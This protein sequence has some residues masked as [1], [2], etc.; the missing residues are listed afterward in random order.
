MIGESHPP[1]AWNRRKAGA[2]DRPDAARDRACSL[3]ANAAERRAMA[4]RALALAYRPPTAG[5]LA[6]LESGAACQDMAGAVEWTPGGA[7]RLA[8]PIERV[9]QAAAQLSTSPSGGLDE[10]SA[11]YARLYGADHGLV[12][13]VES[14][15]FDGE[16]QVEVERVYATHGLHTVA[17]DS[18]AVD[19]VATQLEFVYV[20]C[21]REESAW[22]SADVDAA[23]RLRRTEREFLRRHLATW[24]VA[25]LRATERE[26]T[27]PLYPALAGI[28]RETLAIET[29]ASALR[30]RAGAGS[31]ARPVDRG[32]RPGNANG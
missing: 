32:R 20:L 30:G 4:W 23:K 18:V 27:L 21:R 8:R 26:A 13:S 15:Y 11:E 28:L 19:H 3:L 31:S 6:S 22:E 12:P 2:N 7:D 5:W 29:R 1:P 16:R 14:A 10:A 9:R 25:L 17:C 24:A